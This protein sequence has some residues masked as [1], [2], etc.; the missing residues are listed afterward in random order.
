MWSICNHDFGQPK[1]LYAFE[2]PEILPGAQRGLF[3]QRHFG[4]QFFGFFSVIHA[5]TP[6]YAVRTNL[7]I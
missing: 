4:Y 7:I 5:S 6:V 1:P 3:F 2:I